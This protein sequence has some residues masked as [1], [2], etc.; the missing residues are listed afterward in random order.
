VT[1]LEAKAP[2]EIEHTL[3]S[4]GLSLPLNVGGN[5]SQNAVAIVRTARLKHDITRTS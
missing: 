2:W 3:L 5:P 1:R 4:S